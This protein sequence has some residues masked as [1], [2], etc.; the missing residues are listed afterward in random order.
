MNIFRM[1]AMA[2]AWDRQSSGR[3]REERDEDFEERGRGPTEAERRKALDSGLED[4][5]PGS[6]PVSVT[7][8]PRSPYD[9]NG[10]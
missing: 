9:K 6:D 5:F 2:D 3:R 1:K 8:P 4:S 7:Q 10:A